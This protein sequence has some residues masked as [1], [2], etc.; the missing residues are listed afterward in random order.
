[1]VASFRAQQNMGS[2]APGGPAPGPRE[3]RRF[4][5][6][7]GTSSWGSG[8]NEERTDRYLDG[9]LFAVSYAAGLPG[10]DNALFVRDF[11]RLY[12]RPPGLYEALAYDAALLIRDLVMTH[13]VATRSALMEALNTTTGRSGATGIFSFVD[14]QAIVQP[15][16]M[17]FTAEGMTP[18]APLPL[19]PKDDVPPS[20][21][22]L[23]PAL[24]PPH[25]L[26]PSKEDSP[27]SGQPSPQG[28]QAITPEGLEEEEPPA[29][30]TDP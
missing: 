28:G 12:G 23:H 14:R 7:L 19:E 1:M 10:E 8:E 24:L 30:V 11:G 25:L 20:E 21:G 9:S 6:Y 27:T 15:T 26:P 2:R 4:V 17:T 22:E 3:K 16:L 13:G 29:S 5:T 18:V